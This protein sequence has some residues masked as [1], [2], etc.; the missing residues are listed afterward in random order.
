[1]TTQFIDPTIDDTLSKNLYM[2]KSNRHAWNVISIC[3][4]DRQVFA[5]Q[6]FHALKSLPN[7]YQLGYCIEGYDGTY[8]KKS[9][10]PITRI[11]LTADDTDIINA[12]GKFVMSGIIGINPKIFGEFLKLG[13]L[14]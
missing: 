11:Y 1:M 6:L 2:R 13:L 5:L 8:P 7:G 4:N 9:S 10:L 3:R 14:E 12:L